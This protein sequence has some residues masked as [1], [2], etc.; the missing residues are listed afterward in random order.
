[1]RK[2]FNNM[3]F[4]SDKTIKKV[5]ALLKSGKV[6]Y[7]TGNEC[8][9]FEKEFSNYI[10]NKYAVTLSNGSV[11]LELALKV[12]NLKKRDEIIVTPRSFVISAS[13]TINLGL[14]PVFADVD[15]N[16][17]LS[18]EGIEKVYNKKVKAIILVHL[19]GLSCDLDPIIK[20]A[21]KK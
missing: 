15:N 3:P 9:K 2:L 14:K 10:G 18:L 20:F 21:K 12:L 13:C 7:W 1:M 11:A 17:N 16:G 19:N 5:G 4:Y 8:K 6:N